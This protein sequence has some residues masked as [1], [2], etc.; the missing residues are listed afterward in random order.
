MIILD[1]KKQLVVGKVFNI[2][3]RNIRCEKMEPQPFLVLREATM[4]EYVAGLREDGYDGP[5][6]RAIWSMFKAYEI[7]TD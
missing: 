5:D 2:P 7:A 4:D 6:L 1:V 3:V